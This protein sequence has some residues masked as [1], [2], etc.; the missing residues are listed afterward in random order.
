MFKKKLVATESRLHLE[1]IVKSANKMYI[2]NEPYST[3]FCSFDGKTVY[4]EGMFMCE[5][6]I[7]RKY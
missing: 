2:N 4:V 1:K 5:V 7:E 3:F 6:T